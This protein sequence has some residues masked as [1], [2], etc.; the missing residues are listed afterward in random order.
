MFARSC[1]TPILSS[2][3]WVSQSTR[4]PRRS[5]PGVTLDLVGAGPLVPEIRDLV[6][7]LGLGEKVRLLGPLDHGELL[8]RLAG[9][10]WDGVV[11]TSAATPDAHEGIPVSLMEAMA[12]GIPVLATDS[13][14]TRELIGEG[15]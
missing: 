4:W 8:R 9:R 2:F 14:G 13:G 10:E 12:A 5:P 3:I 1:R 6:V 15:A 7:S 11:L